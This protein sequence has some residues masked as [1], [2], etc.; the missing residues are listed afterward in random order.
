MT[1]EREIASNRFFAYV[2][3]RM[4]DRLGREY[5]YHTIRCK[6]DAVVVVPV[7]DDGRLV[8]ER[9]WRQPYQAHLWEFP[10]GGIDHGEEPLAAAARELAEETGWRAARLASMR[11]YLPMPGLLHMRVHLV[12]AE[13]LTPGEHRREDTEDIAVELMDEARA[14]EL[15]DRDDASAF[16]VQG[17]LALERY[18][19]TRGCAGVSP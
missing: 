17:M 9:I 13:G 14:W 6:W 4:Q 18:R 1:E 12:L 8:V 15:A 10:A 7:L 16:L 5:W 19:R 3:E 11:S 2:Q